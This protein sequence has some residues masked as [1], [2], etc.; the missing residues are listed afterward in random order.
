LG[1]ASGFIIHE[2]GYLLTS[3]HALNGLP[4]SVML[5][6]GKNHPADVVSFDRALDLA[7][8]KITPA[9]PL[10]AVQLG[11]PGDLII[12]ETAIVIG[13]PHGQRQSVTAGVVS[14]LNRDVS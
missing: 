3:A 4:M 2:S 7:V 13:A 12:G 10:K 6:D 14:A 1:F 5:S 11:R 9:R 8:L